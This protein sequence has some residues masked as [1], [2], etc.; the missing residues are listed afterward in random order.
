M[1]VSVSEFMVQLPVDY[2]IEFELIKVFNPTSGSQYA[3]I[4]I[5]Q[6]SG[7]QKNYVFPDRGCVHTLL[8]LYV[9]ATVVLSFDYC[10]SRLRF[11]DDISTVGEFA[12][13]KFKK[14]CYCYEF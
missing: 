13:Y 2:T 8:T 9:Y 1:T 4:Y 14:Y 11:C 10:D 6:K 7:A 12:F 5:T 3:Q